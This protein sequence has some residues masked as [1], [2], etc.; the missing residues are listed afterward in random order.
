MTRPRRKTRMTGSASQARAA[1]PAAS[2]GASLT[3]SRAARAT[4][5]LVSARRLL[6]WIGLLVLVTIGVMSR[7]HYFRWCLHDDAFISF[8]YARNL[9]RGAGLVMNPGE[10]VEGYTNFLW[11]VLAAPAF[12]L[13]IDPAVAARVAGA[14]AA[15]VLVVALFVYTRARLGG[16]WFAFVA[17]MFLLGNLA[18]VMESLSGLETLAFA[19]G[20]FLTGAAF[21]EERNHGQWPG[22]WVALAAATTLVRPEGGLV[23]ATLWLWDAC[24]VLRGAS[25]RR[26]ALRRALMRVG[27]FALLVAPLV[28]WRLVYYDAWLPNTF[29]TKVGYTVAQL[30]RGWRHTLRVLVF[31]L[32]PPLLGISGFAGMLA[33]GRDGT[34]RDAALRV[35]FLLVLVYVLYVIGVGGDY[36]PTARFY[37]PILPIVYLLFQEGLRSV[38]A[39]L[40]ARGPTWG[41][42]AQI[43]A[44]VAFGLVL[45]R[46]QQRVVLLLEARG[47]PYTRQAHHEDLRAVGEWFQRN[48]P[49]ET[50][51][52]LSSIG[53]L[54]YYADRPIVDMMGLTEPAIGRMKIATM[55][56]G[57]SG[58]EKGD[59]ALVL[60]RQPDIVIFD[61]GNLFEQEATLEDVRNGAR[62][63]SELGLANSRE[64]L[65]R[66]ELRRAATPA[67]VLHYFRMIASP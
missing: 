38:A 35:W 36:E 32:T 43:L 26:P 57:P 23:F 52:A 22:L 20:V 30:D 46:S 39:L 11:T 56:R 61:K 25:M 49:P 6:P 13:D 44:L 4:S 12:W 3:A 48:T 21:L 67:G 29:Y 34:P 5:H 51:I 28:V 66:Y 55:G 17:P 60:A 37:M 65:D 24:D 19:L 15:L 31:S 18:V 16:G 58:H 50:R 42:V 8:R 64:F 33:I 2:R 40:R 63:L 41:R 1:S 54:P 7:V 62:G 14:A 47:W 10:R 59:A 53:A 9:A 27:L 45:V